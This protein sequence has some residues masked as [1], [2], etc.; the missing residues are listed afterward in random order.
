[1]SDEAMQKLVRVS[2]AA[3]PQLQE[4]I[5]WRCVGV[6]EALHVLAGKVSAKVFAHL[7]ILNQVQ[8]AKF[9]IVPLPIQQVSASFVHR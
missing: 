7:L 3:A 2:I 1:M 4:H 6:I 5:S 8:P 9:L